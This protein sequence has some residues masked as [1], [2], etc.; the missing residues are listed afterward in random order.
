MNR[1]CLRATRGLWAPGSGEPNYL[2][3]AVLRLL[4]A[5][6]DQPRVHLAPRE[7][8]PPIRTGL[9]VTPV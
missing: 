3:R 2:F 7:A 1:R 6:A 9:T 8:R 4:A 5:L